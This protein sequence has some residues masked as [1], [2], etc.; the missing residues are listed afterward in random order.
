M[1]YGGHTP[2]NITRVFVQSDS[3]FM[4]NYYYT[5]L[6][7]NFLL[8]YSL[9]SVRVSAVFIHIIIIVILGKV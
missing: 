3:G 7:S 1:Q 4:L 5:N 9:L 6:N 2:P 8:I